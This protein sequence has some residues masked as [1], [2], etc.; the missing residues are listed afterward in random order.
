[1]HFQTSALRSALLLTCSVVVTVSLTLSAAR[2][3][4]GSILG[5]QGTVTSHPTAVPQSPWWD[6]HV[7]RSCGAYDPGCIQQ[8]WKTKCLVVV[9]PVM[10]LT[11]TENLINNN[12]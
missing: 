1:M 6:P 8:N 11:N 10:H 7:I 2:P 3:V 12:T 5:R 4:C 9:L